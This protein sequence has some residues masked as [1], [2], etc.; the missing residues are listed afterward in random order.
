MDYYIL[1][2][3]YLVRQKHFSNPLRKRYKIISIVCRSVYNSNIVCNNMQ[4]Q[5][6]YLTWLIAAA[7]GLVLQS[8]LIGSLVPRN[9]HH[10]ATRLDFR[11]VPFRCVFQTA[12]DGADLDGRGR[13]GHHPPLSTARL[14]A[15]ISRRCPWSRISCCKALGSFAGH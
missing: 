7:S 13:R 3:G 11:P 8:E 15:E 6:H 5:I 10:L 9:A 14:A 1:Y 2:R 12:G 4:V